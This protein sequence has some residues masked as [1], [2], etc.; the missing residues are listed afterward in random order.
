PYHYPQRG[1]RLDDQ[2]LSVMNSKTWTV[3]T[4]V[5]QYAPPSWYWTVNDQW[6][7]ATVVWSETL[8]PRL[9]RTYEHDTDS[10]GNSTYSAY[11]YS[12]TTW[13]GAGHSLMDVS[14]GAA[15]AFESTDG[16]GWRI[17]MTGENVSVLD[18]N[19]NQYQFSNFGN[20]GRCTTTINDPVP[21]SN[22]DID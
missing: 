15:Q 5:S 7:P 20:L 6:N 3:Q 17:N 2:F 12:L 19:G 14:N 4:Y 21:P 16:S 9:G 18:G 13:D 1:R 11:G 8:V 22:G 10:Q